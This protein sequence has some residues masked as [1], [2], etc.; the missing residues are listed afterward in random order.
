M[1]SLTATTHIPVNLLSVISRKE[2]SMGMIDTVED[3][4]NAD[5]A[6]SVKQDVQSDQ[7]L[8]TTQATKMRE[9]IAA[10]ATE[11]EVWQDTALARSNDIL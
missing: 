7:K 3:L 2:K 9:R 5:A 6:V 11:R 1:A 10:L 8:S 4:S